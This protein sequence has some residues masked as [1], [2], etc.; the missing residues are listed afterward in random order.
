MFLVAVVGLLGVLSLSA[1][2]EKFGLSST[3]ASEI[4]DM[5]LESVRLSLSNPVVAKKQKK[6][7][8]YV[9][10][11][12]ILRYVFLGQAPPPHPRTGHGQGSEQIASE[13]LKSGIL[14]V[15]ERIPLKIQPRPGLPGF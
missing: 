3:D 2:E 12:G 9:I 10:S 13:P 11:D 4:A 8:T 6:L 7:G 5:R 1:S 14:A 15:L